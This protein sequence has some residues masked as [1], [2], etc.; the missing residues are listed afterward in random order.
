MF[1]PIIDREEVEWERIQEE[2]S[3]TSK[4]QQ[5]IDEEVGIRNFLDQKQRRT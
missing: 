5:Q 1:L 2:I 4:Q 3:E